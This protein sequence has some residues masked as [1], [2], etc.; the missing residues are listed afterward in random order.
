MTEPWPVFTTYRSNSPVHA[1]T[2]Q[3][4]ELTILCEMG[5]YPRTAPKDILP[6]EG[7]PI[8]CRACLRLVKR[9]AQQ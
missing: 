8:T 3:F 5:R 1:C 9:Q 4:G 7:L 2:T 6:A